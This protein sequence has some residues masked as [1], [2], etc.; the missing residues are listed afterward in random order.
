[1]LKKGTTVSPPTAR[2]KRIFP[3]SYLPA[4]FR[5][6]TRPLKERKPRAVFESYRFPR[7]DGVDIIVT[8]G[9]PPVLAAKQATKSI[10]IV[11]ANAEQKTG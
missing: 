1:M 7:G 6:Q 10:P 5:F 3:H 4:S 2:A 8:T 9:T 11:A